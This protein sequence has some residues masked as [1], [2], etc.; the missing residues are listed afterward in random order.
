MIGVLGE[1]LI[2]FIG[3]TGTGG[4]PCFYHYPGGCALNTATAAARLDA[5]TLYI[6]KLSADMFGKQMQ[7]HFKRNGVALIPSLCGVEENSM[8]GFAKLDASGAA[9]YAFYIEGT[10]VT[11]LTAEEILETVGGKRELRYLH[12]G[13]VSIALDCP[14]DR[15]LAALRVLEDPPFIFLDPNVRPS[16]IRNFDS[17]RTRVFAIAGLASLV[18]L[19][20]ED[21]ALLYPGIAEDDAVARLLN[22]GTFHVV[23]TKGKDGLHWRSKSG[24]DEWVPAVDNPIVDTVGAG[25]TVSGA[26]LSYLEEHDLRTAEEISDAHAREALVFAAAAAAVTT[27]RKGADPPRRYEIVM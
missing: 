22:G 15:I 6:G 26:I 18:K 21:L 7:S 5:S 4:Q 13:S 23:L 11:V 19:S 14:G 10:T 3:G 24:I 8:I 25:D 27:S 1:A 12:V 17:Y 2:D 20:H 9:S 16:V